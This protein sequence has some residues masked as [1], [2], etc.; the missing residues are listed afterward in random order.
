MPHAT[1]HSYLAQIGKL[2][3]LDVTTVEGLSLDQKH[4]IIAATSKICRELMQ[5]M[6]VRWKPQPI[7]EALR[8]RTIDWLKYEIEPI[9]GSI[10]KKILISADAGIT[11]TERVYESGDFETKVSMVKYLTVAIYLDDMIDK[12]AG[13]AKEAESFL[14]K[15]LEGNA[16]TSPSSGLDGIWLEQYRKISIELSRHMSDPFVRN[17]LLHSCTLFIEG[18]ALEY[19]IQ[20]DQA[21]YFLIKDAGTERA[22]DVA[23]RKLATECGF[24]IPLPLDND[25]VGAVH[26]AVDGDDASGSRG[27]GD[28]LVP[29]GWPLWLRERSAVAET[30]AITSFRAPGDVDVPTWL[31]LTAISELRTVIL[32]VNDLLSFAKELL[33]DDMTSSISVL[34]KERRLIGIPGT[35]PD[36]G[37][38][39]RD[40]FDEVFGK[41]VVAG[42]RI[43]RLLRPMTPEARY[44]ADGNAYSVA[45]LVEMLKLPVD[46]AEHRVSREEVMKALAL[47]LWETHQRGYVA[48]HF[49]SPR[50]RTYE[51]FDWVRDMMGCEPAGVEYLTSCFQ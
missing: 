12:N 3:A 8:R 1:R 44:G 25:R 39:L 15:A 36:G 31:W 45:E 19:Y 40:S 41:T 11:Y 42:A 13:L 33:A 9:V 50:Y 27:H 16:L 2:P 28:Y 43:N 38:C 7:D 20:Q 14:V 37:W 23:E 35:A 34:T 6:G 29:N 22:R 51:L 49:Q 5:D 47:K 32:S 24:D 48:W 18:C 21:K 26:A 10:N 46:R 17:M 4:S 30:F